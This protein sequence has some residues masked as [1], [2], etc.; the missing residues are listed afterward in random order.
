MTLRLPM[1]LWFVA[2]ATASP[3]ILGIAANLTVPEIWDIHIA[4]TPGA[5]FFLGL[6]ALATGLVGNAV[7]MPFAM[8]AVANDERLQNS[9]MANWIVG[10]GKFY[11]YLFGAPAV[12]IFV[13]S[14]LLSVFR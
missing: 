4:H 7:A 14:V 13:V 5:G 3:V 8:R 11:L 1:S 6:F 9:E 2:A 12:L 10:S